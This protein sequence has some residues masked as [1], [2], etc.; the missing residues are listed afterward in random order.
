[1]LRGQPPSE[2]TQH[3]SRLDLPLVARD[4]RVLGPKGNHHAPRAADVV[5]DRVAG[6]AVQPS[7]KRVRLRPIELAPPADDGEDDVLDHVVHFVFVH[8]AGPQKA[9]QVR[10]ERIQRPPILGAQRK[11][12]LRSR[13]RSARVRV[14]HVPSGILMMA[15]ASVMLPVMASCTATSR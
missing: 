2:E 4:G 1:M 12:H 6:E 5:A 15:A 10:S 3:V 7:A 8:V 14:A 9:P 13:R 11:P